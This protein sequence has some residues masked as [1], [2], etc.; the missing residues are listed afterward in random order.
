M[1]YGTQKYPLPKSYKDEILSL[2]SYDPIAILL[3][4]KASND[5][6]KE[7]N[8]SSI[9]GETYYNLSFTKN[10]VNIR[11][12][13]NSKTGLLFQA[14]I[15]T[16]LPY[17]NFFSPFG[18][19]TTT[20]KYSLYHYHQKGIR[21]PYQWD[22]YR[23]GN[24]WRS[25]TCDSVSFLKTVD[26]EIFKAEKDIQQRPPVIQ[27]KGNFEYLKNEFDNVYTLLGPW[28][29][30][31]VINQ[32][33]ILIIEAPI[34]SSYSYSIVDYLKETYPDKTIKGVVIAS[35]AYPHIGGV[36]EY[37]AN[38]IPI[39]T[40]P[41]NKS[42]LE[43]IINATYTSHPDKLSKNPKAP[44][45]NFVTDKMNFGK[46]V[47]IYPINGSAG[48]KM[49]MVHSKKDNW[50]YTADLIQKTQEGF[51]MPQYLTEVKDAVNK[52]K[53]EVSRVFG[54]HLQPV[55]WSEVQEYLKNI[56]N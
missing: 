10:N 9:Q 3:K 6:K 21:Y 11:I 50:L 31:L 27:Q 47:T 48:S 42:L 24:K 32:N 12:S 8:N 19:F 28:F 39:V 40:H 49:L 34:S 2:V 13:I 29:V 33:D 35:D 22:I 44:I 5:L 51:F 17:E 36:R 46:N 23:L 54:M 38:G 56:K 16:Y 37:V 41:N 26:N 25:I 15:E 18:N 53:L 7:K 14:E 45:Y 4:A 43:K 55:F 52:N 20:V 30:Q 1:V